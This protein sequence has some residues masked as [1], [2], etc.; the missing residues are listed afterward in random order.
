ML[1]VCLHN[2]IF[3]AYHG[4][5]EEEKINGNDFEINVEIKYHPK[6]KIIQTI[7]HT[8]N[9]ETVFN[10]IEARMKI[11]TPLLETVAM[12]MAEEILQHFN[13]AEEVFISIKKLQPPIANLKG[14]VGINY[15]VKRNEI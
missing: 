7:E 3:R 5:Y 2:I 14:C 13:L 4:L 9:Y 8:I 10:L 11:A 6:E 1:S 12:Q 15:S